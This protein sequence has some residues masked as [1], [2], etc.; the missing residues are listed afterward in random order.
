[1]TKQH[2][3]NGYSVAKEQ[4]DLYF[5]MQN[6]NRE[7]IKYVADI[8]QVGMKLPDI[9]ALCED[10]L[11]KNGADSFWYWGVGAFIFAGDETTVSISGK[12][13]KATDRIIQENDIITIDLSPQKNNIWGDYAR[14]LVF[15]NGILCRETGQI[16]NDE[17]RNGL[18]MEEYLHKTLI[19]VAAPN[20]TFEELY[21]YM[22]DLI[23]EKGFFN[24]DFLGNLGHSIVK[25]KNDRIY[26]EKGNHKRLSDVEM[27][28][29]EPHISIPDSKYGYKREDIY[30]FN[31]GRLIKL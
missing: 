9:K 8:I 19:D 11:L 22:N 25:N 24:L 7:T 4:L 26:T 1:M 31:N 2:L 10:Y 12:D 30:Y 21:Y 17:W 29:F 28:T 6:L 20:M 5:A 18:Q 14:T 27:F 16:K 13:Y 3:F 23:A 15:E